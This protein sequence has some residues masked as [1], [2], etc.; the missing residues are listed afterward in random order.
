[1]IDKKKTN[2]SRDQFLIAMT[3]R[4]IGIG[5]H[6]QSIASHPYYQKT[7]HFNTNDYPNSRRIGEQTV[8]LPLSPGLDQDKI[9]RII[10][11]VLGIINDKSH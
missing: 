7:Y 3:N 1:M 5:V 6:Y 4:N 10:Q 2:L 8:S 9:T 11:S